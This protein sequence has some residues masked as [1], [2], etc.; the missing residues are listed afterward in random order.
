[1][2]VNDANGV[3]VELNPD[4]N[5]HKDQS[6]PHNTA[7]DQKLVAQ[8]MS[9]FNPSDPIFKE[10][11]AEQLQ[12]IEP[13]AYGT[14][15]YNAL[16]RLGLN[17]A[18][19]AMAFRLN[20]VTG[21]IEVYM[22]HRTSAEAY[23]F[24]WHA[25]GSVMRV[26]ENWRSVATRLGG[27]FGTNIVSYDE[28]GELFTKEERGPFLSKIFLVRLKDDPR[29]DARHRWYPVDDL[30]Q[31]TVDHHEEYIIPLAAMIY[32]ARFGHRIRARIEFVSK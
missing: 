32:A 12:R 18:M 17:V 30:P 9:K 21:K 19:E 3:S 26:G 29:E 31:V 6:V 10:M 11:I 8:L 7:E 15:L 14:P 13:G 25:P 23:A 27:E 1:M 16:A 5:G 4:G 2:Q 28:I 20:G 22:R 24:Q